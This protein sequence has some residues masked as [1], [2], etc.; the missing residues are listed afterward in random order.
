MILGLVFAAAA[1]IAPTQATYDDMDDEDF[2][3]F[4]KFHDDLRMDYGRTAAGG[5]IKGGAAGL[6]SGS[7]SGHG[8]QFLC[9]GCVAGAVGE[10]AK[11]VMLPSDPTRR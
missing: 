6:V 3:A 7:W 8:F 5:C 10:V 4:V 1:L 11:E 2:A 9:I